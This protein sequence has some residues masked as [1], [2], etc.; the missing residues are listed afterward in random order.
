MRKSLEEKFKYIWIE[1]EEQE[2]GSLKVI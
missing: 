2:E 1:E